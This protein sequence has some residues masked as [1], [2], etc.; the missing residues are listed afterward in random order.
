M[1]SLAQACAFAL[2][3]SWTA[4]EWHPDVAY[5]GA[6]AWAGYQEYCSAEDEPS[7]PPAAP[8]APAPQ[9]VPSPGPVPP[10]APPQEPSPAPTPAPRAYVQTEVPEI[11]HAGVS[12]LLLCGALLIDGG[13]ATTIFIT[14][15]FHLCASV[16]C[17]H[18]RVVV[19]EMG[20]QTT[21]CEVPVS[22]PTTPPLSTPRSVVSSP[23]RSVRGKR[24][25]YGGF[26]A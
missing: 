2:A 17:K 22:L 25:S 14:R 5:C 21:L 23:A 16:C 20:V 12:Y 15:C 24:G 10:S 7:P 26:A 11:S 18:G 13:V 6:A 8:R 9:P 3:L 1:P 4:R 19:H